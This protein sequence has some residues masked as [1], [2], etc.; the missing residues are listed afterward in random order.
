MRLLLIEKR[1]VGSPQIQRGLAILRVGQE[2]LLEV[3]R[4]LPVVLLESLVVGLEALVEQVRGRFGPPAE[5]HDPDADRFLLS[6]INRLLPGAI[7]L[8]AHL[9]ALHGMRA[10]REPRQAQRLAL[11]EDAHRLAVQENLDPVQVRFEDQ[12]PE[13]RGR[14]RARRG[15]GGNV[16]QQHFGIEAAAVRSGILFGFGG[17]AHVSA[18]VLRQLVGGHNAV[19][20]VVRLAFQPTH[21]I[22]SEYAVAAA[23]V[24]ALEGALAVAAGGQRKH[25]P[26]QVDQGPVDGLHIAIRRDR[27]TVAGVRQQHLPLGFD[28]AKHRA[29]RRHGIGRL[30]NLVDHDVVGRQVGLALCNKT[31]AGEVDQHTVILFG[32]RGQ[33]LFQLAADIGE[34]GLG[35]DERVDVL[36]A[37]V[38]PLGTDQDRVDVFRV[39]LGVLQLLALGQI[40]ILRNAD[41]QGVAAR[42]HDRGGFGGGRRGRRRDIL[43]NSQVA[44]RGR[45]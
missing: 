42:D 4:G 12:R 18:N 24:G 23:P 38:A 14:R 3:F 32:G 41:D 28:L 9:H 27:T 26:G 22:V 37:E 29:Q 36:R 11:V 44:L 8:V 45:R 1:V 20:V 16:G 6:G 31:V 10:R 33:P 34:R 40:P 7:G 25:R 39:A 15:P 19:V 2:R 21:Q 35:A 13:L 17:F 5:D 43:L 30:R